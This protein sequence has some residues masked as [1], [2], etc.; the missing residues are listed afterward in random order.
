[1]TTREKHG[2]FNIFVGIAVEDKV[3]NSRILKVY[4]KELNPFMDGKLEDLS[5]EE[6]FVIEDDILDSSVKGT[7][8]TTNHKTCEYFSLDTNRVFPPDIVKGEQV[9][10]FQ[11]Q[12]NDLYYWVS[13]GRDDRLRKGELMRI[14]VSDD[15][16]TDK[17]LDDLNTYFLEL[18]TKIHKRIRIV[19]NKSDGEDFK[20]EFVIDAKNNFMSMTDDK[21]NQVIIES[22]I[23]RVKLQNNNGTLLD[24][25]KDDAFVVC[26]RDLLLKAKRQVVL[27]ATNVTFQAKEAIVAKATNIGF[28]AS[29]LMIDAASFGMTGSAKISGTFMGTYIQAE[30]YGTGGVGSQ[31]PAIATKPASGT[32]TTNAPAPDTGD[33]SQNRHCTAQEQLL[34]MMTIIAQCL[35]DCD[36]DHGVSG[37]YNT[38]VA[39]AQ[40]SKMS[41]NRG[42]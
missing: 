22:D 23:P 18:D 42:E 10:I 2:N 20:Y 28:T 19:T 40:S 38:L 7:V 39:L 1:M 27:E 6:T 13:M 32:G 15:M 17:T 35:A 41:K 29:E 21:N 12:D 5:S 24:L 30:N 31:Y 36:T 8:T 37:A 16:S 9:L 26:P 25:N 3:L 4:V 11:Y 14:A 33:G 34:E